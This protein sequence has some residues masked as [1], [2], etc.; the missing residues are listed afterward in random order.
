M[1][2]S[3]QAPMR[4]DKIKKNKTLSQTQ[5]TNLS[6][7]KMTVGAL[8]GTKGGGII[9]ISPSDT[10]GR[11]VEILRDNGIGALV[12][13]ETD[14]TLCGILSERDIV[15]KLADTPGQTLPKLVEEIM[16]RKVVTCEPG[17]DL[18]SVLKRM[19]DGRFRHMPVVENEALVGMVTIGDVV[20]YRLAEVE[21]EALQLKQ[22]VVG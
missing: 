22:L 14:G 2:A 8:L 18:V 5:S 16:V 3:Y 6:S 1:P 9:S 13:T 15:R 21:H 4:Q 17:D 10:L 12:V 11:A 20:N 7:A 19:R